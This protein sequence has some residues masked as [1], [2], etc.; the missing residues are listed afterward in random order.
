[1]FG[2]RRM[3]RTLLKLLGVIV[4]LLLVGSL[5][6]Q[7]II[8]LMRPLSTS[9]DETFT[10]TP[11]DAIVLGQSHTITSTTHLQTSP[12]DKRKHVHLSAR[13]EVSLDER[14]A[15]ILDDSIDLIR[16]SAFPIAD[17][18]S[19]VTA[20]LPGMGTIIASDAFIREGL[21]YFFPAEA[22]RRSFDY[23]DPIAQ[24]PTPL[25]YV[26]RD[27]HAG[28]RTYL[29]HQRVNP[30]NL[31]EAGVRA[32]TQPEQVGEPVTGDRRHRLSELPED[33]QEAI[34][35]LERTL[36]AAQLYTAEERAQRGLSA[37]EP[38]RVHPYYSVDRKVWVEPKSGGIIDTVDNVLIVLAASDQDAADDAAAW[39]AGKSLNPDRT[40]LATTLR[41]DDQTVQQQRD[42]AAHQLHTLRFFQWIS[43][44]SNAAIAVVAILMVVVRVRGQR[45]LRQ[46]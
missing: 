18:T 42:N 15:L 12:A 5:L 36:P 46:R 32:R 38:V 22:E 29:F 24:R 8:F 30:V 20:E 33:Q 25:D 14:P 13:R 4:A 26:D 21:Q 31:V 1:M 40:V 34:L 37:S 23:F 10:T 17:P 7:L 2:N 6:P 11:T 9:L 19:T 44:V 28:L 16:R 35:H 41:W 3:R 39:H 45:A 43:V 27:E